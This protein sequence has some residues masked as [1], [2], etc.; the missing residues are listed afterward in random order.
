MQYRLYGFDPLRK[1]LSLVAAACALAVFASAA[2]AQ[3]SWRRQR[4]HRSHRP[5]AHR[6]SLKFGAFGGAAIPLRPTNNGIDPGWTAGALLDY[7]RTDSPLGLR[8]EGS[9]QRLVPSG[10][11]TNG[12]L[13]LWG[14][15]LDL[16]LTPPRRRM[17]VKPY[18]VGGIGVY[19]VKN[20]I[21][22]STPVAHGSTTNL[23]ANG[24][25]GLR[26]DFF[27]FGA[28]LEARYI[29]IFTSGRSTQLLP[30]RFGI[31]FGSF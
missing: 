12:A 22:A 30:V 26:Y 6:E 2:S 20:D 24:G 27:G 17:I 9:Y 14:G 21:A 23:A 3:T 25:L 1:I 18:I 5:P 4:Y 15:D 11:A 28:F 13:K 16:M 7:T 10:V 8:L 19:N 29:Q 31:M